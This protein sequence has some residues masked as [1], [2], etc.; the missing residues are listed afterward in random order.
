MSKKLLITSE[1]FVRTVN[2]L[3]ARNIKPLIPRPRVF[4]PFF[5]FDNLEH[6]PL[7]EG[8]LRTYKPE[9]IVGFLEKR[10]GDAAIVQIIEGENGEKIFLIKTGDIDS[11]QE[12]I[13]R[14][15]ALCGYFPSYVE[16]RKNERTIQYEPRH[17]NKVNELVNDEEYIYHLTPSNKVEKI[18][19]NGLCPKTNNKK[20]NY[21]G[22]V[23]FFL[24]EPEKEDCLLLMKQ[25]YLE[26]VKNKNKA[27]YKGPYTL[28]RI[29][30]EQI[31]G[32]DFSYDPNVYECI[33]TYDNISPEAI[34]VVCEFKQEYI[35]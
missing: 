6:T 22:R 33:Y 25:F 17:Q 35:K 3:K 23:Y 7:L 30:T 19:R 13:D 12:V 10:Y 27:V 34:E 8:I 24:H 9:K 11:N 4:D 31:K 21:P 18:L 29:D 26:D 1:Q 15:M 20:F 28:L 5:L 16:K 32:I 14:D 2:E